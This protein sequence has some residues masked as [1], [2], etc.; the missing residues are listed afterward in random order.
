MLEIIT[1]P[2][3]SGKTEELVRRVHR[4]EYARITPVVFKPAK[5]T[6]YNKNQIMSHSGYIFPAHPI[7]H[8][9]EALK[10]SGRLMVFDEAQFFDEGIINVV[11]FMLARGS[12]VIIAGLDKDYRGEPFGPMPTLLAMADKVSKL[13]AVCVKC[14][15][16]ATMTQRITGG[17]D[18][19]VV[20]GADKYEARCRKCHSL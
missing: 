10:Y 2:M 20:G 19:V 11:G 4:A 18:I 5:D 1:G 3:F 9:S 16:D 8:S 14:Y 17:S 13:T 15:G 6:R 12:N 7:D